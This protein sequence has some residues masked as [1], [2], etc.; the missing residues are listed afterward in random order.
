MPDIPIL[1]PLLVASCIFCPLLLSLVETE[2]DSDSHDR[3]DGNTP[4]GSAP[5]PPPLPVGG[6]SRAVKID[7]VQ[8]A[9]SVN[10]DPERANA[11]TD[12]QKT[13]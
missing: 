8:V 1:V 7:R 12:V 2:R 4:P 10:V 3:R 13:T 6:D 11:S 5:S 9:P